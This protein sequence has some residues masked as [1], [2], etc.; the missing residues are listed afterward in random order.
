MNA[1]FVTQAAE[2]LPRR[3]FTNADVDRMVEAGI[4]EADEPMELIKGEI[5]PMPSEHDLHARARAFLI[6]AFNRALGDEWFV[7]TEASLF[8]A[9]DTEF[10][11]DLHVFDATL[12]SHH[13]RGSDVKLAVEIAAS[14]HRRDFELKAPIYAEAGV[15]ELWVLDLDRRLAVIFKRPGPEGYR[16]RR[17]FGVDDVLTPVAFPGVSLRLTDLF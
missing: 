17:E 2:G 15:A 16:E 4:L 8:L 11:P 3:R 9:D 14:S 10:K 6:R 5:V 7:A 13:V 1:P 12:K